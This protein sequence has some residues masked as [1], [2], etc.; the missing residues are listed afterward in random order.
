M[1]LKENEAKKECES[2]YDSEDETPLH[3]LVSENKLNI[4]FIYNN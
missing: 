4:D 1:E 3:T 2:D